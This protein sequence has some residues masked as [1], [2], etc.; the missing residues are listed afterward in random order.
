[1]ELDI[2]AAG[3][4][5]TYH[6]SDVYALVAGRTIGALRERRAMNQ[7]QLA[8]RLGISQSMVS[9]FERGQCLP[10]LYVMGKIAGALQMNEENLTLC[11][12]DAFERTKVAAEQTLM[13]PQGGTWWEAVLRLVGIAGLGGLA[14]FAVAAALADNPSANAQQSPPST[15][16]APR[17]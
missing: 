11:I 5:V 7:G 4:L 10:D 3:D 16:S 12:R 15:Q 13:R 14:A 1:M 6:E 8:E 9:R 2:V 17:I